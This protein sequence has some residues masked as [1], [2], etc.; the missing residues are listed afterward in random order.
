MKGGYD[1]SQEKASVNR[2]SHTGEKVD[3]FSNASSGRISGA[4]GVNEPVFGERVTIGANDGEVINKEYNSKRISD[5]VKED[6]FEEADDVIE[7]QK[8]EEQQRL[9]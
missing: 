8:K 6:P 5:F 2:Y 9:M 4:G 1:Y 3:R 7:D